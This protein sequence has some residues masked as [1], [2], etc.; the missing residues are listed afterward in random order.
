MRYLPAVLVGRLLRRLVRVIRPGGGSA[1]PGLVLSKLAPG[2]LYRVLSGFPLGLVIITGSAG[3][4]T[5]TKMTVAIARA[6]GLSV[7]TNPTT[8]NILQGYYST[9][10]QFGDMRGR[11]NG[12]IAI[13][14][15]DEGH[16]AELVRKVAPNF[17]TI[18]NVVE[19]QLD[20][21]VDPALVREKLLTVAR[22]A[23][24]G[25]CLNSNDQNLI[26][27]QQQLFS[28][29]ITWFGFAPA[30]DEVDLHYANTYLP[31]LPEPEPQTLVDSI[32]GT[33]VRAT[34]HGAPVDIDLPSRGAHFALDAAAALETSRRVLGEQ[35][36]LELAETTLNELPP[37]FAR[38]E[39]ALVRGVE[40]EFILIQNPASTQLNLDNL[41]KGLERVFF[42]IG[43]DVH[44]PSWLWTVD[45]KNLPSVDVVSGFNFAEAELWLLNNAVS[46]GRSIEP[47]DEAFDYWLGLPEPSHSVR[48]V[49]FSAD[50][51]RRTRRML[52]LTDPEAVER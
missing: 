52:G 30:L 49:I 20:R 27:M 45:P 11:V 31:D 1:L 28:K 7:F 15:M 32:L 41:P 19:D 2:L 25:V 3:K 46:I 39:I 35:F 29:D 10:L 13:L 36:N 37:V 21:F 5:T 44:D 42:A 40:I 43:R 16:A 48:T 51:M 26:M 6:H 8:A 34:V 22:H 12:Q 24:A 17:V 47:L 38:G 4:S 33:R 18:L 9:I 50:A 23:S 14:E